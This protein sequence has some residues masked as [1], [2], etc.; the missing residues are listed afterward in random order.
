MYIGTE[1]LTYTYMYNTPY[2]VRAITDVTFEIVK[3]DFAIVVGSSGSGK[4]TLIQHLNG[5]LKPTTGKVYFDNRQIGSNKAELIDIRKQ[6]G[7]VFQLAE[8]HF[9]CETVFDEVAF[10]PRNMG[11]NEELISRMVYE[12]LELVNLEPEKFSGRHPFHLSAGQKRL[13]AIAAA[14]SVK[15]EVLILDEPTASLDYSAIKNLFDIICKFNNRLGMTII[16]ATHH[17]EDVASL[18]NSVIVLKDGKMF[19]QGS[20][21]KVFSNKQVME[22]AG[23]SLPAVTGFMHEL[24]AKNIPVNTSVLTL[25]DARKEIQGIIRRY[26]N[27]E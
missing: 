2:A 22:E 9:F 15:P 19:L 10:A 4:S 14:I 11:F 6:I 7:I 20:A 18:A 13:V 3:G 26:R 27:E 8:E 21:D 23:L 12:A 25:D 5:L 1:K 17:F 24:L 16:I